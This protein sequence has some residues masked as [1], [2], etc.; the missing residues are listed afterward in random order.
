MVNLK[1]PVSINKSVPVLEGNNRAG[2]SF[3]LTCMPESHS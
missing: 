3:D 1:L 2:K